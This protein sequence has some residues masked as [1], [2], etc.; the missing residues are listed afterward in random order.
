VSAGTVG[1]RSVDAAVIRLEVWPA[2]MT[3]QTAAAYLDGD[4]REVDELRAKGHIT[5]VGTQKRVKF[6]KVQLDAY[7]ESMPERDAA[8]EAAKDLA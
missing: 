2:L 4:V 5:P 8:R 1:G 6:P 7:I 3:R